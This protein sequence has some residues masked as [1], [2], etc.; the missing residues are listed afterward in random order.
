MYRNLGVNDGLPGSASY[1]VIN[2]QNGYV[3]MA[4]DQ[5]ISRFD[6][7]NF[8]NFFTA[9]NVTANSI[10]CIDIDAQNNVFFV[11][12][13]GMVGRIT[14]DQVEKLPVSNALAAQIRQDAASIVS[15]KIDTNGDIH[16]GTSYN[17]YVVFAESGYTQFSI[18]N[19]NTNIYAAIYSLNNGKSVASI[20][21]A[22][23][24]KIQTQ[25]K[26]GMM[27]VGVIEG[28]RVFNDRI[29]FLWL[30]ASTRGCLR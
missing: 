2:D 21:D 8:R 19:F 9:K 17:P 30:R 3:W 22:T 6:G 20:T 13:D 11:A 10:I 15:F 7:R 16:I 26:R 4:G 5:G 28:D 18:R 12:S 24:F 25:D 29:S 23:P 27:D 14:N 1:F